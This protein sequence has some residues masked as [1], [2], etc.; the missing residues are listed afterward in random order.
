MKL[1]VKLNSCTGRN[2]WRKV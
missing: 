2:S 1:I